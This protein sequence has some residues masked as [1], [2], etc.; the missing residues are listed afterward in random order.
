M[1][2]IIF[3]LHIVLWPLCIMCITLI[4]LQGG[5][6]DISSAFG[7]GG[8]LDST[9]GVGASR[10]T[11]RLTSWIAGAIALVVIVL[12][13]PHHDSIAAPGAKPPGEQA[14][15]HQAPAAPSQGGALPSANPEHAATAA[16]VAEPAPTPGARPLIAAPQPVQSPPN[17]AQAPPPAPTL[18][19]PPAA[20]P[21]TAAAV[22]PAAPIPPAAK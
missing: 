12:D 6:G 22:A 19:A 16:S 11:A 21:A 14:P 15:A 10:K 1:D 2:T 13:I 3:S 5:A 9:L 18:A 17:A 4:L 7:G 20:A 8:Q